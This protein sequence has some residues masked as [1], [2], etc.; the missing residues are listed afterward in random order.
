MDA[1]LKRLSVVMASLLSAGAALSQGVMPG[2]LA[3]IGGQE[4]Y[5]EYIP[6]Q[7]NR[8]VLWWLATDGDAVFED[9]NGETNAT[10]NGYVGMIQDKSGNGHH[11]LQAD[12][13]EWRPIY[14]N[15][16]ALLFDATDDLINAPDDDALDFGF[17]D[18][19]VSAWIRVSTP[20]G[21]QLIAGKHDGYYT[22]G[23]NIVLEATSGKLRAMLDGD[24]YSVTFA[25]SPNVADAAWHHVV[26]VWDR[27]GYMTGYVDAVNVGECDISTATETAMSNGYNLTI[28]GTPFYFGYGDPIH[29]EVQEVLLYDTML[30]TDDIED[31]YDAGVARNDL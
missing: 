23:W 6:P 28:G 9:S 18:F 2:L 8:I 1:T 27:D 7:T 4:G 3:W 12:D 24:P 31:I 16:V 22:G 15:G 20:T 21:Y 29:G 10:S 17:G 19:S 5:A 13:P 25:D 30:T 26:V 11:G 14:S